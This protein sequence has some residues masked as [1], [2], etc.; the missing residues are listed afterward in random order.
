[1]VNAISIKTKLGWV[2]AYENNGKIFKIRFGKIRKQ[3][4]SNVLNKLKKNFTKN[5]IPNKKLP[6][7]VRGNNIKHNIENYNF[8]TVPKPYFKIDNSYLIEKCDFF[9]EIPRCGVRSKLS[10]FRAPF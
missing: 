1:M 7:I 5:V 6:F 9:Q 10:H 8:N 4:P 3:I 2:S